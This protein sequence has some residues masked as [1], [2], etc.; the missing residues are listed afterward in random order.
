MPMNLQSKVLVLGVDNV[1]KIEKLSV[2]NYI[3]IMNAVEKSQFIKF[4]AA[5]TGFD[6]CGIAAARPLD[7]DGRKLENWLQ[8]GK[9]GQM[10]YM[11]KHFELRVNPY[12]LLPGAKSVICFLINYFPDTDQEKNVP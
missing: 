4:L 8:Q 12:K 10:D 2:P 5:K 9:H 7:E 1:L 11:E 6:F 3:T